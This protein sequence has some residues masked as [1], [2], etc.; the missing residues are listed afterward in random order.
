MTGMN[1]GPPTIEVLTP[2]RG[3]VT[4]DGTITVTG[5]ANDPE[6]AIVQ[7]TVNGTPAS[8]AGDGSFEA[9][10]EL[11]E[12]ITL[13]ETIAT[14]RG[15]NTISDA[16]A[17]L[18]GTLVDQGVPIDDAIA[19]YISR[20]AMEGLGDLVSNF[21]SGIDLT[22][23]AQS[24]NPVVN[25]GDS[26]NDYKAYID[27]VQR[28]PIEVSALPAGGG[29]D[30]DVS[31]RELVIRGRVTWEVLCVNGGTTYTITATAYDA[32]ALIRP[33]L[34]SGDITIQLDGLTSGFRSFNLDVSGLPGFVEDRFENAVRDKVASILRDKIASIVP[35]LANQFLDGFVSKSYSLSL[36]GQTVDLAFW[37][38]AMSWTDQGG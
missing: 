2:A 35:P 30:A 23:L 18:S 15:N 32:G 7:V 36:F 27:S 16:R 5:R 13:I 4:G 9:S 26:C 3:T 20:Q 37:P 8:L 24:Y 33:S 17:V 34:S 29:I 25:S 14:D 38:S 22:A 21:A 12:G 6:S 31:I 10:V 1:H 19:A 28:G 11:G